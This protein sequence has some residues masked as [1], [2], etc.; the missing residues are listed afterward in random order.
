MS[1]CTKLVFK[2]YGVLKLFVC[3]Y[4]LLSLYWLWINM[5]T[6]VRL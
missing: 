5:V 3:S 6:H 4:I 2:D 1:G